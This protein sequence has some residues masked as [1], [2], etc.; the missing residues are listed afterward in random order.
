MGTEPRGSPGRRVEDLA[1]A[2]PRCGEPAAPRR[3]SWTQAVCA[4]EP[5][6]RS[7]LGNGRV[8]GPA[9]PRAR[10]GGRRGAAGGRPAALAAGARARSSGG[11]SA[12]LIRP[13]SLVRVQARPPAGGAGWREVGRVGAGGRSLAGRAPPLHG[14]GPGF[15][16]PRL[17]PGTASR[18]CQWSCAAAVGMTARVGRPRPRS[19]DDFG[20]GLTT[21]GGG[22][23]SRGKP[24]RREGETPPE[25]PTGLGTLTT[26]HAEPVGFCGRG[27]R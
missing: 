9:Q 19:A 22:S 25:R 23:P 17:H 16:S 14:G 10:R 21:S 3:S 2:P 15:E 7:V 13:R 6:A 24:P 27:R 26:R 5:S 4:G 18:G 12:A 20:R 8:A 1:G 11:Q